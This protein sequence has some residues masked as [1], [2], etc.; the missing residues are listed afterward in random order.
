LRVAALIA[1]WF[2]CNIGVLLLNKALLSSYGF[3]FPVF[4][5]ALHVRP[6]LVR[7]SRP[8]RLSAPAAAR[9]WQHVPR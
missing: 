1:V 6:P 9:R 2:F 7:G 5:T 4:L 3:G 8:P